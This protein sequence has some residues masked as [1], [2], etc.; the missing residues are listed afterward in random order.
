MGKSKTAGTSAVMLSVF[1]T[2]PAVLPPAAARANQEDPGA[3]DRGGPVIVSSDPPGCAQDARYPH[4]RYN[5]ALLFGWSSVNITF[6]PEVDVSTITP[7]D[8][9]VD[10]AGAPGTPP[11]IT[12]VT[13]FDPNTVTVTF[14]EPIPTKRWT[15]ITY[16][17]SL[18]GE[19]RICLGYLPGN[20]RSAETN[21][22][23]ILHLIDCLTGAETCEIWQCDI[24]RN[25]ICTD[26]P[27]DIDALVCLLNGCDAFDSWMNQVITVGEDCNSNRV[28]DHCDLVSG[29]SNDCNANFALDDC[30]IADGTSEDC[31]LNGIPDECDIA[32]GTSQD[33]DMD[34][35]PDECVVSQVPGGNWTDDIWGLGDI[36]PEAPYPDNLG[37]V[38]GLHVTIE[39]QYTPVFLD[40]TVEVETLQLL[41]CADLSVT[42]PTTGDFSTNPSSIDGGGVLLQGTITCANDRVIEVHKGPLTIEAC[43]ALSLNDSS[44]LHACEALVMDS[45][46]AAYHCDFLPAQRQ[47]MGGLTPPVLTLRDNASVYVA[48]DLQLL[49]R[50]DDPSIGPELLIDSAA[51]VR[52]S[53]DFENLSRDPDCFDWPGTLE[54]GGLIDNPECA[55]PGSSESDFEVAGLDLGPSASGYQNN[56]AMGTLTVKSGHTVQ[57]VNNHQNLTSAG[58][59]EEALYVNTLHLEAGSTVRVVDCRVYY[60]TLEDEGAMLEFQGCGELSQVSPIPAMTHVGMMLTAVLMITAG[61]AMIHIR[62]RQVARQALVDET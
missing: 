49:A 25:G 55:D 42:G 1:L 9:T 39:S 41:D 4:D 36:N 11:N 7:A 47:V 35:I 40:K 52:L 21:P 60:A 6:V 46:A 33:V 12:G 43:G 29:T 31:N 57:F 45:G 22:Q 3:W 8:F 28:V 24:D 30:D 18:N 58:G 53:G 14:D 37:G 38:P 59:C 26:D 51:P 62:R 27:N 50:A 17:P 10:L 34:G 15:C 20:V 48:G 13:V 54:F 44:F 56:F 5:A 23:D 19:D 2:L 32:S 16:E 61:A